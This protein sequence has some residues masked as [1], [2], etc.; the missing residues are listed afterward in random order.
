MKELSKLMG[1]R[2]EVKVVDATLRDGGL[3]NDFYFTD[4]FVKDLYQ[5][6]IRAGVDYMEIGYKA[7]KTMFDVDKFGKWKF[8]DDDAIREVIGENEN[9]GLKLAVMADVGRCNYKQDIAPKSESPVDLIRVATYINTIPAAVDMIEDAVNKGY[10]TTCNIMAISNAQEGD[11]KV[12]LDVL[13]QSPVKTFYIVDSFGA[14]YPE[15]IARIADIYME[16]AEKY[17]KQ[18]GMHAHNNQQLAFA[19]TI[20]AV[21]D[22]VNWLDATYSGMGRGAGNCQMELLLGFLRNPKFNIYP[23]LQFIENYMK[24]LAKDGVKW[25]YDLQYLMTGILNQHPRTAIAFTNE[26]REDYCEFYK[27]IVIQD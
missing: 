1:F 12:A 20:E 27:E 6:N 11:L 13:G 24:P 19:N 9:T 5:A 8:C 17:G 4:Q 22:G 7:D 16:F 18:V 21:G 14:L 2:P 26:G 25:G 15:Q 23:V 3:V 10:E